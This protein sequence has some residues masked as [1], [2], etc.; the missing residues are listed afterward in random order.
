MPSTME[1]KYLVI[2]D[3][4]DSLQDHYNHCIL[5][6]FFLSSDVHK[7][8]VFAFAF[9]SRFVCLAYPL[10]HML[11]LECDRVYE[12]KMYIFT[13]V[14]LNRW[15]KPYILTV[16]YRTHEFAKYVCCYNIKIVLTVFFVVVVDLTEAKYI[17]KIE[18]YFCGWQ[19]AFS[20][21][22]TCK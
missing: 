5:S 16:S 12:Q 22:T 20:T 17:V 19:S 15:L 2:R 11:S 8:M 6:V 13:F 4:R 21:Y 14:Y 18:S 7:L 1:I 10:K 9:I 3:W